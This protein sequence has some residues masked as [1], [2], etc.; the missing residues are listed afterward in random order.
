[1]VRLGFIIIGIV[2]ILLILRDSRISLK[3]VESKYSVNCIVIFIGLCA[4]RFVFIN[5]EMS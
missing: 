4:N 1:M 3:E 2:S 5:K